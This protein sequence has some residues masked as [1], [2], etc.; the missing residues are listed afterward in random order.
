MDVLRSRLVVGLTYESYLQQV[1]ELRTAY[2]ELPIDRFSLVC[3]VTTG[4]PSERAL[5]EYIVATNV[6]GDCLATADCQTNRVEPRLQHRW[7]VASH[8]LTKAQKGL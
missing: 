4:S 7:Q 6:W 3:L 2:E 5:N 8:F 1:R